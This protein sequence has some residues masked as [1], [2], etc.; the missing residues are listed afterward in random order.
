MWQKPSSTVLPKESMTK[1]ATYMVT[2]ASKTDSRWCS[3]E[4][5][6]MLAR[7]GHI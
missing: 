4:V 5:L 1:A 3:P 2:Q 6:E 7:A